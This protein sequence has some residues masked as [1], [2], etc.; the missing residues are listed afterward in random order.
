MEL[1]P[2]V[3]QA[4]GLGHAVGEQGLVARVIVAGQRTTPGP[5]AGVAQELR[6]LAARTAFGEVEHDQLVG[7]PGRAAVRPQVG[8]VRLARAWIEHG[9]RGLVGVQH[10]LREQLGSHRIDQRLLLHPAG[11][12]PLGQRRPRDRQ[13]DSPVDALLP[14]QR[15]VRKLTTNRG[16]FP[17]DEAL[18][19][20]F[21]L[22]L[23]NISQNWT[24]PIRD[25]KAALTRFTIQFVDRIS[26]N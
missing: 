17:S 25:W 10:I 2:R 13:A 21:Y 24:M 22:A 5:L 7:T 3:R 8:T 14:V 6:R 16:S 4:P 20:L 11:T 26:V 9:H 18:R 15:Q 1:A 23:R 19:K 12:D